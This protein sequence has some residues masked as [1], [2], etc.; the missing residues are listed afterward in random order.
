MAGKET[1]YEDP[2]VEGGQY[3][4][5]ISR[6]ALGKMGKKRQ[7]DI[8]RQWFYERY[9]DPVNSQPYDSREGGYIYVKGGPYDAREELEAEFSP[10][11]KQAIIDELA[12]ELEDECLYWTHTDSY[13][14]ELYPD[15]ED[16]Y[17]I[18]AA[19]DNQ[20]PLINLTQSLLRLRRLLAEK[21]K[22]DQSLHKFQL[23]MIYGFC[24][25]SLE[26]YLSDAFAKRVMNDK[27]LKKKYLQSE[28]SLKEQKIPLSQ[29]YDKYE[30]IDALIKKEISDTTFHNLGR[31]NRLFKEVLNVDIG[32]ISNLAKFIHKRHDFIHRGGK[33][34]EGKEVTT[35]EREVEDLIKAVEDFCAAI[36]AKIFP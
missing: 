32:D 35:T 33:D 34:M 17:E 27:N 28:Q 15:D 14:L 36:D 13:D 19:L 8:M 11:V 7:R 2:D 25:T 3:R 18:N 9:E 23:M 31:V 1:Y 22:M 5:T 16:F 30:K 24:I 26:A 10:V 12:N 21:D 6:T 4:Y 29:V 20:T